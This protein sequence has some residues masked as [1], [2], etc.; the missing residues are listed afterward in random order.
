MIKV[1]QFQSA[2]QAQRL[3]PRIDM[4]GLCVG[5]APPCVSLA[6]A[7]AIRAALPG[8][9]LAV[10]LADWRQHT[11]Q[12]IDALVQD[13]GASHFDFTPADMAKEPD[14]ADDLARLQAI[15]SPKVANGFFLLA[16]DLSF[17][18]DVAPYRAM[19]QAGVEWFQFEIES[20]LDPTCKLPQAAL[21]GVDAFLA[22]LPVLVGDRLQQLAG[23]PLAS[24]SGFFF[25]L[26]V[27]KAPH[28]YDMAQ[29]SWAESQL[30]RL[31][32]KR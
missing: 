28:N 21:K 26:A 16:D 19:R 20:A 7:L 8:L 27:P 9:P 10:A 31:L 14:F 5:D 23:Y 17:M 24:A 11:P 6:Q 4:A 13:L 22:G 1:N 30:M 15:R 12:Q 29:Q 2:A 25:D 3:A 32:P 18:A